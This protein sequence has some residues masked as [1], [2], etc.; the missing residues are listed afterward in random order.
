MIKA[1]QEIN[2]AIV[3]AR[4]ELVQCQA[5]KPPIKEDVKAAKDELAD[6]LDSRIDFWR[7]TFREEPEGVYEADAYGLWLDYGEKFTAPT[8]SKTAQILAT[9]DNQYPG[10]DSKSAE[11][12]YA[13]LKA[14][15]PERIRKGRMKKEKKG[16]G[17]CLSLLLILC[18][19]LVV[20]AFK[21]KH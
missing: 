20:L 6:A 19:V 10:W 14:N 12:F 8:R 5:W 4:A 7:D 15:F 13:T 2:E 18:F 21:G 1:I 11:P 3:K 16:K 17:G 9:L